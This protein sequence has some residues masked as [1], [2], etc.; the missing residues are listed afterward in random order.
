MY[1]PIQEEIQE[2]KTYKNKKNNIDLK[3]K[4]L[5]SYYNLSE[6]ENEAEKIDEE[7][8]Q[9]QMEDLAENSAEKQAEEQ[10]RLSKTDNEKK[11][12][13]ERV[14]KKD[15]NLEKLKHNNNKK[16]NKNVLE[17]ITDER[18]A[19]FGINPKKFKKKIK[20]TTNR[21]NNKQK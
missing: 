16:K 15:S 8:E 21:S 1:R 11:E 2:A 10:Q 7:K 14:Y 5:A 20:Y 18:L 9:E 13:T 4:I 6:S 19:A 3:K 17:S 12:K